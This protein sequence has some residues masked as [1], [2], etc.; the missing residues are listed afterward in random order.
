[1]PKVWVGLVTA[2]VDP[3]PK[4]QA[5]VVDALVLVEVL[6]KVQVKPEQDVVKLAVRTGGGGGGG[7]EPPPIKAV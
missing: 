7:G 2:L 3:S 4:F 5:Y 6:V 1:M